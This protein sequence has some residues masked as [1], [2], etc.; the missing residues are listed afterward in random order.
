MNEQAAAEQMA[1]NALSD[2]DLRLVVC[3]Q[4]DPDD[5]DPRSSASK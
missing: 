4:T 2:D 1:G 5:P 3:G